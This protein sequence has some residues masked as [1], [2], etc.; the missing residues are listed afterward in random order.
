M[1]IYAPLRSPVLWS[2]EAIIRMLDRSGK[3]IE[4]TPIPLNPRP[5]AL[6]NA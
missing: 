6:S 4:A 5:P 2:G 3:T 1:L